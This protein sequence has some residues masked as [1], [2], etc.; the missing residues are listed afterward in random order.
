MLTVS[1]TINSMSTSL[2]TQGLIRQKADSLSSPAVKNWHQILSGKHKCYKIP[3]SYAWIG[4]TATLKGLILP[5]PCGWK[6]PVFYWLGF[7]M[8]AIYSARQSATHNT[9]LQ[10]SWLGKADLILVPSALAPSDF[11]VAAQP[12]K[13]KTFLIK[14]LISGFNCGTESCLC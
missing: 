6:Q 2:A 5:E 7:H 3:P 11:Q 4:T 12:S 9:K 1:L 13:N 10:L 14:C 8:P